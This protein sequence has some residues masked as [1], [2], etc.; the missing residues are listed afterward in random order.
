MINSNSLPMQA[1]CSYNTS[2]SL[3]IRKFCLTC[4]QNLPCYN[5]NPFV[6]VL[7]SRATESKSTPSSMIVT[8]IFLVI[9]QPP[10]YLF[11]KLNMPNS[12]NLSSNDRVSSLLLL[13]VTWTH[14]SL[15]VF[16]FNCGALNTLLKG[17]GLTK[18]EYSGT[19]TSLNLGII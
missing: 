17:G 5:S 15:L 9:M 8:H 6:L 10:N 4:N 1:I 16:L 18:V 13:L 11:S 7:H 19:I 3:S 12:I 14:S 2:K